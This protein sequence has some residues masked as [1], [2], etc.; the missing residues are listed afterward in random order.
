MHLPGRELGAPQAYAGERTEIVVR[1]GAFL[2]Q[3]MSLLWAQSGHGD[4]G[5]RCPLLTQSRH[6]PA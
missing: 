5:Q 1:L 4:R 6:E 3:C 2:L